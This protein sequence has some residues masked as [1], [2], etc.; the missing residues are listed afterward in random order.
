MDL[1]VTI[2]E[3]N[4]GDFSWNS[5]C[6]NNLPA[7]SQC[8]I[9]VLF[10][11]TA[12]AKDETGKASKSISKLTVSD[13]KGPTQNV[14]LEGMAHEN[15]AVSPSI[16]EFENQ[17]GN[18]SSTA[19]T[20]Q[21][22][23]YTNSTVNSITVASTGDFAENHSGC[24]TPIG[25]GGSCV[26]TVTYFPK[27]AGDTFGSL[28]ITTNPSNLG[29]LPRVV[30]LHGIGLNRCKA[31]AISWRDRGLMLVVIVS[32]LY[33][34]GLILVRW[35][36]IAKPARAQIVAEIEA[37][38]SRAVAE[39]AG[40]SACPELNER[41]A[42]IQGLLDQAVYPFKHKRFPITSIGK[43]TTEPNHLEGEEKWRQYPWG[44]TR[45]FNALFWTRG[46]EL[47]SWSLA[48][49]AELH[50]VALLP[51]ER[52]RARLETAEQELRDINTPLAVSL[53][54]RITQS[55]A[56]EE[57]LIQDPS[58]QLLQQQLGLLKPVSV[59]EAARQSVL[60]DSG[61]RAQTYLEGV[62]KW[63]QY[64]TTSAE[65]L[66]DCK[67][68]LQQFPKIYDGWDDLGKELDQM[69]NLP[70]IPAGSRDLFQRIIAFMREKLAPLQQDI[71]QL[72]GNPA[73]TLDD[74]NKTVATLA[75]LRVRAGEL[76]D[77]LKKMPLSGQA[78]QH[79]LGLSKSQGALVETIKQVITPSSDVAILQQILN[80][81]KDQTELIQKIN[82]ATAGRT[83]SNDSCRP[84]RLI[85]LQLA[86][87]A[88]L[89]AEMVDKIISALSAKSS[90]PLGRWRALL[91][92]A[93]GL[94]YENTDNGFFQ[95]ASW[96]NKMMWLV[97]C[98]LLFMIAL[99]VTVAN[100]VLL[101]VGAV[102]GLLCRLTRT[103]VA[104]DVANDYGATWG[105]LFLSP[106]TGAL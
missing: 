95:L 40:L 79:F 93:L 92:E 46:H 30:S 94:I 76:I 56:S 83:P 25:P 69:A 80:V 65:N 67:S 12:V 49:E 4:G 71:S 33:F 10:G 36:M 42:C 23:N 70:W 41:L 77:E 15:V 74:C 14:S 38:R 11:L 63:T 39:M 22:T 32:G 44:W 89:P 1:S 26:I 58:R 96:H 88:P 21:L 31:P 97:G 43:G 90:A 24:A 66:P 9:T 53:A 20:V 60:A 81:L 72:G 68:W 99:A 27:Q 75:P 45:F 106:L 8:A 82:Q 52:V 37:V 55:L 5:I 50:L 35:H 61:Q 19:R 18:T 103:R 7:K 91:A 51:Q 78:C 84:I 62:A 104:A 47:A 34:L 102:G 17:V 100:A 85:L 59:Q 57:S 2:L 101:L 73:L 87:A 48:H 29:K 3:N 64:N 6:L 28:T 13:G 86:S 105:F 98:A 54:D 16:L